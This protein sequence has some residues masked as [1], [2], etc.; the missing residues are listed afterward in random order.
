MSTTSYAD[1]V[2]GPVHPNPLIYV[3]T[4]RWDKS[5]SITW[6]TDRQV[7]PVHLN[8]YSKYTDLE[9]GPFSPSATWYTHR[10][11]TETNIVLFEG[12]PI[13]PRTMLTFLTYCIKTHG[14]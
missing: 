12:V 7:G 13:L 3:Q 9:V 14:Y 11:Y 4:E 2:V 5:T 6:Y 10:E 8:H 1:R